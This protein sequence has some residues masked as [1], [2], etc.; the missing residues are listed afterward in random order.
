MTTEPLTMTVEEAARAL[1]IGK[2]QCYEA[3]RRGELPSI[4]IGRRIL[5]S[6]Q[7]L[8][9]MINGGGVT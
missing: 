5:I 3:V 9:D 2:N 8:L 6:R 1:G 7:K 4:S